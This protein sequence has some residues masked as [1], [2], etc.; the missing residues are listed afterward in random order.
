[1]CVFV[2]V[3]LF[4]MSDSP[5]LC[6]IVL[7]VCMCCVWIVL[8]VF[9]LFCFGWPLFAFRVLC[10]VIDVVAPRCFCSVFSFVVVFLLC[11]VYCCVC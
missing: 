6:D 1:M 5:C 11:F 2:C 3:L 4:V 9:V 7:C 8:S 10:C